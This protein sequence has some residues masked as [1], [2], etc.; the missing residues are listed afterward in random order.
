VLITSGTPGRMVRISVARR[1]FERKL[2]LF[3]AGSRSEL[4]EAY[5]CRKRA[6]EVALAQIGE[7]PDSSLRQRLRRFVR[8]PVG[9]ESRLYRET[10]WLQQARR[11]LAWV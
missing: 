7:V 11:S 10:D 5:W 4:V 6:S 9:P 8:G 1:E 3:E 2:E